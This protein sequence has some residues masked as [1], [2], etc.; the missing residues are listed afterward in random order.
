[1]LVLV[2]IKLH[3]RNH[4]TTLGARFLVLQLMATIPATIVNVRSIHHT[5][6]TPGTMATIRTKRNQLH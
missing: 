4:T 6:D 5:V 3:T 2:H 1:M